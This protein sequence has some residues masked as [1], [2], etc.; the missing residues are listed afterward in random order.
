VSAAYSAARAGST[1]YVRATGLASMRN[2]PELDAFLEAGRAS[3]VT[4]V[5]IDLS[6]VTGMDS[7]FMGTLVGHAQSMTEIGGR[8]VV[9]R[10]TEAG[11]K[12]LALLGVTEVV[13]VVP[14]GDAPPLEFRDLESEPGQTPVERMELIHRAHQHLVALGPANQAKFAPFLKAWEADLARLRSGMM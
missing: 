9:V 5:C 8:L 14:T 13:A 2:A 3:G 4:L 6:A 7:T 10:P 12:L 1:V 11:Q